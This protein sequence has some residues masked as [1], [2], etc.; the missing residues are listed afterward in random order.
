MAT[1]TASSNPR[2]TNPPDHTKTTPSTAAHPLPVD[3]L[4]GG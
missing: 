3:V 2:T 1:V 4:N